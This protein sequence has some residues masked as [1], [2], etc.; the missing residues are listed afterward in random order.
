MFF[1]QAKNFE[2]WKW[3]SFSW[4]LRI[5]PVLTNIIWDIRWI[6]IS[7]IPASSTTSNFTAQRFEVDEIRIVDD[8]RLHRPVS[9]VSFVCMRGDH[10]HH[11][12]R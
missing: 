2:I 3:S 5:R 10:V 4:A 12:V 8:D 6:K 11:L 9:P 7:F 1:K